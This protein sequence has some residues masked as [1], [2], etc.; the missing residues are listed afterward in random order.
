MREK[1][2]PP[3]LRVTE[4]ALERSLESADVEPIENKETIKDESIDL[5]KALR[6]TTREK[7]VEEVPIPPIVRAS[8]CLIKCLCFLCMMRKKKAKIEPYEEDPESWE[9]EGPLEAHS[10]TLRALM[11]PRDGTF[12]HSLIL[13]HVNIF[14]T[15]VKHIQRWLFLKYQSV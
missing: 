15:H 9:Y 13:Q 7:E 3:P 4:K 1:L 8:F 2:Q 14:F 10:S 6:R 5:D 12:L 11:C